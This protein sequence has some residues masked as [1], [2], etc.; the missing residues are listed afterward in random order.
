M[1]PN[2]LSAISNKGKQKKMGTEIF[3]KNFN[4]RIKMKIYCDT[5]TQQVC[6]LSDCPSLIFY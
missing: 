4:V 6:L 1:R 2:F 3:F 5:M